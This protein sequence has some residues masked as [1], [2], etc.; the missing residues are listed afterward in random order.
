MNI[1]DLYHKVAEFEAKLSEKS[2]SLS[3]CKAGCS[4]CC[5][6]DISVFSVEADNIRSWFSSLD[7]D[8]KHILRLSWKKNLRETENFFGDKVQSCAFLSDEKCSIYEARPLICRTQGLAFA[9]R[10][11]ETSFVDICPLNEP[12]IDSLVPT[13]IVNLDL[14]NTI[15]AKLDGSQ[16]QRVKLS[17]LKDEFSV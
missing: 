16:G 7:D 13:D 15:L 14:L 5:Y 4:R 1:K 8:Q 2:R 6:T 12:V 11:A 17:D 9:F 10:E 3:Q